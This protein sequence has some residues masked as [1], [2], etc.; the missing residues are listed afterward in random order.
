MHGKDDYIA[1]MPPRMKKHGLY[2]DEDGK[3]MS[4]MN[5]FCSSHEQL[6][7]S[8]QFIDFASFSL[9]LSQKKKR[10]PKTKILLLNKPSKANR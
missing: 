8:I 3:V 6:L 7:L 9:S 2:I 1:V 10:K 5:N 4:Y